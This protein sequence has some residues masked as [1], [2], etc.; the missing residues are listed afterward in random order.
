MESMSLASVLL[1]SDRVAI[2]EKVSTESS[3]K[4]LCI[5]SLA[6]V[7]VCCLLIENFKQLPD[8]VVGGLGLSRIFIDR[9]V[10]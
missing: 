2:R 7:M 9:L 10:K 5:W 1:N 4:Y 6:I 3:L 8:F